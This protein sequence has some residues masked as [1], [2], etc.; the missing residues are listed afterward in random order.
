[1]SS[2]QNDLVTCYTKRPT[3]VTARTVIILETRFRIQISTWVLHFCEFL[4]FIYEY[5]YICCDLCCNFCIRRRN[6]EISNLLHGAEPFLRSQPVFSQSKNSLHLW[7]PKF[8]YCIHKCQLPVSILSQLD[9]VRTHTPYFLKIHLHIIL[10]STPGFSKWSLTLRFFHQ[11]PVYA[12][13]LPHTR[14]MPRPSH[15]ARFYH[16]SNIG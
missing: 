8:H 12:S 3:F 7:N 5:F 15:S 4:G 6:R 1:V 10:P 2:V 16:P 11:N 9:L 13:L 14:Y